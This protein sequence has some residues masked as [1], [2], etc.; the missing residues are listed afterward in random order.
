MD[1]GKAIGRMDII[2]KDQSVG[3]VLVAGGGIGGM[4]ASLDLAESGF[5]VYLVD[6]APVIGGVMSQLDKTFPTNDCAMCIMS[7]KLVGAGR[8]LNIRILS[9]AEIGLVEGGPGRFG[10]TVTR[11]P[12]HISSER[13]TGCGEC[14]KHCP[15]SAID[16]YNENMS[17]RPAVYLRYPQGVPKVY[18]IDRDQCI[19]CGLCERVCLARAVNYGDAPVEERIEVGSIILAPGYETFDPRR[20]PEFGYGVYDN[21]LTSLEFER[22]LS[23]TGPHRGHILRPSDGTIP[24][25]IAFIQCVGSRDASCGNDYCSSICCMYATKEAIIAKEHVPFIRPTIFYMDIRAHG[26]GFD[27]YYERAKADYGVRY[28]K[29]MVSRVREQVKTKNLLLSY[30]NEEGQ[31]AEEEFDL[32]VLSVGVETSA[33]TRDLARRL[34][35]ELDGH[36][37]CKTRTFAPTSTSKPGIYVCGAF[38]APKDIPETVAQ[39]SGAAA[40]ASEILAPVRGT[41]VSRKEYPEQQDVNGKE[42]RIGVFVCHC[43]INI[44]GVVDVPAVRAY[45]RT[46]RNVVYVEENLYTCSQDTQEKMRHTIQEHQLNRVIVASCSPRTHEPL[47]RETV[48]ESGLNQFLFEMANIRDQCSWVHMRQ[49][50]E[51]TEKAKDLVRMAVANARMICPLEELPRP[52]VKKGLVIGGGVAGMSAALG[53]AQQGFEVFLVEKENELGGNLRRLRT[54]LDGMDIPMYLEEMKARVTKHPRIQ[55]FTNSVITDFSGYVGNFKTSLMIGPRM[56]TREVEHGVAIVATGGEELKPKEYLYGEDKRVLTQMEMEDLLHGGPKKI[57]E[58]NEIVMIQCVGSRNE[59]RPYCSR[60]CC[61][62]AVK[63]ALKIKERNP[64]A[65]IT[66]LYRDM[67]TYGLSELY[68]AQAREA[69]ILFASYELSLKPAVT[70]EGESLRVSYLDRVLKEQVVLRPDLLVLSA[71]V[72]PSDTEEL[73]RILKVP[74][75]ADGFFLEA[76]MKLRPVDFA[77][78]GLYLCGMAHSPKR[79]DESLSQAS[80][81][82]ARACT[83]L[84]KEEIHVGGVVGVV[85]PQKCAACLTCVRVCPYN[86]PVINRDGVAEIEMAKCQGCGSCAAECPGRAIELM[87]FRHDQ[88]EAKCEALVLGA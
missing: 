61:A 54:T 17:R 88:I 29:C 38:E 63:N 26:K 59:E 28:V 25:R 23:A 6:P 64:R 14:A 57:E 31:P 72:V 19:G 69:G 11:K 75:T 39:A 40:A 76:H 84:S 65:R 10:V 32:V 36:G 2:S 24:E 56:F 41:K 82:V 13:C 79:L 86:V 4:Q 34:G 3:A 83:V 9:N 68:Y 43:G 87:H 78:E 53:L 8:H 67:R 55:V 85:D 46:L 80:A 16:R 42:P 48:R 1:N 5:Y 21:V 20:R 27:A 37:F 22:L 47:F 60:V 81:A 50:T 33:A 44:G 51:A 49:K 77:S 66:I 30:L 74:R 52:V 12:R 35:V 18:L 62:G 45:A 15:V 70:K 7:P 73:A 58:L 71:A